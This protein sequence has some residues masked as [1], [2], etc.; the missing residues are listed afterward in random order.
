MFKFKNL[1]KP[2]GALVIMFASSFA[3][4]QPS[5][6]ETVS[7]GDFTGSFTNTVTSGFSMRANDPNCKY[8]SGRVMAAS[9]FDATGTDAALGNGGCSVS[10]T[11]TFGNASTPQSIPG[12]NADNGNANWKGG[13]IIDAT[14]SLSTT[15]DVSNSAGLGLNLSGI[16]TYNPILD[17]NKPFLTTFSADAEDELESAFVLNNAYITS[18]A[19][20]G[21][22]FIDYTIGKY[23]ES[24]GV[25][26]LLPIGVNV[27]NPIDLSILRAPG[28]NIKDALI[29]QEMVGFSIS[30]DSG[31]TL[32]AYYQFKQREIELDPSGTFWSSDVLG[33]GNPGLLR[34]PSYRER[35]AGGSNYNDMYGQAYY[36]FYQGDATGCDLEDAQGFG[37]TSARYAAHVGAGGNIATYLA[38]FSCTRQV[39]GTARTP[40]TMDDSD[41]DTQLAYWFSGIGAE[42]IG[43]SNIGATIDAVA[44]GAED[45]ALDA[46]FSDAA[47]SVL[48]NNSGAAMGLTDDDIINGFTI[49]GANRATASTRR[50]TIHIRQAP[51]K[52]AKDSGQFGVNFTG[53]ADIGQGIDYGIYFS[54]YH[55]NAPYIQMLP[56]RGFNAVDMLAIMNDPGTL[57]TASISNTALAAASVQIND[58][59]KY[60]AEAVSYQVVNATVGATTRAQKDA[61]IG[62]LDTNGQSDQGKAFALYQVAGQ[63]TAMGSAAMNA[64]VALQ[65]GDSTLYQAYYPEDIQVMG[66]SASTVLE[67]GIAVAGEI[68]FRPSFPLQIAAGDQISNI[69]DSTGGTAVQTF[70]VLAGLAANSTIQA[71]TV[72]GAGF[73]TRYADAPNVKWSGM[74]D[75]DISSSGKAST[76]TGYNECAGHKEH[77]VWTLDLNATQSFSAS[78]PFTKTLGADSAFLFAELGMVKVPDINNSVG[79]VVS[80]GRFAIGNGY[81]DGVPGNRAVYES[82]ALFKNGLLGDSYCED[83]PG[84]D[85]DAATYRIR[86]GA[87]YNNIGNSPWT[88]NTSFGLN[89]DFY[90]NAPSS[91]GGFVEDRMSMNLGVGFSRGDYNIKLDY[92]E[93]MG[94]DLSNTRKDRDYLSYS[95]S[96]AF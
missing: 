28:S 36:N 42:M 16:M 11:D 41:T 10:Y 90:G 69:L 61:Y 25:T 85:Q 29:P 75:C 31:P 52:K 2:L 92:I 4:I 51:T 56:V 49:A 18:S 91:I 71:L 89:H 95:M 67:G 55:S 43:A 53:Y 30:G 80:S 27:V 45:Q 13:D 40:L 1:T 20:Q 19:Q 66:A 94:D 33:T 64:M 83:E 72:N 58:N 39:D 48:D 74:A 59:F 50:A 47:G 60:G 84:A 68:A 5:Y 57:R 3:L 17:F 23:V 12:A 77:D 78:H 21:D 79:G 35:V 63:D 6:S 86:A 76:V 8:L 46:A 88:M 22:V 96:V 70:T 26:G 14:Q 65:P 32:N 54:N 37:P 24:L 82:F 93:E 62:L 38:N 87:T 7:F 73:N 44:A 15:L 81:C 9:A 34:T